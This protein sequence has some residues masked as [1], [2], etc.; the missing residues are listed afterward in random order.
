MKRTFL[1]LVLLAMPGTTYAV[2]EN[3]TRIKE[4]TSTSTYMNGERI[5]LPEH[6][7][8]RVMQYELPVGAALPMH[9]HPY[10]RYAYIMQGEVEFIYPPDNHVVKWKEGTFAAEA[11]NHWHW[12]RNSGDVPMKILVIDHLPEGETTNT[13]IKHTGR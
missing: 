10:P 12:G 8:L 5:T 11:P 6:P 1:A 3:L 7:N 2:D 4:I 13:V 9:K